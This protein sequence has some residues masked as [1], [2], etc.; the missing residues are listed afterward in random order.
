MRSA[1]LAVSLLT[2]ALALVG[3]AADDSAGTTA[4]AADSS[5]TVGGEPTSSAP[6][7]TKP[8]TD[9]TPVT[10]Q[11]GT[12]TEMFGVPDVRVRITTCD[13][14][15]ELA[16]VVTD[17]DG[18]ATHGVTEAG[19]YRATVLSVPGGCHPNEVATSTVV[20][21]LGEPASTRFLIHCA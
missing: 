11:A 7:T 1:L 3:C 18:T 6:A 15:T 8:V 19:C 14:D 17:R 4:A 16:T 21:K 20:V 10:I 12:G 2:G 9:G 13:T 5:L